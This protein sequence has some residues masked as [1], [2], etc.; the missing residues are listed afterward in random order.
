MIAQSNINI[1]AVRRNARMKRKTACQSAP[2]ERSVYA[3]VPAGIDFPSGAQ[4]DKWAACLQK[5]CLHTALKEE[6]RN[7][8]FMNIH[9]KAWQKAIGDSYRPTIVSLK[10]AGIIRVLE[11]HSTG[12]EGRPAF[13]KS[14]R[15]EAPY[16]NRTIEMRR[17][18]TKPA[19]KRASVVYEV[20]E[21]NLKPA[22]MHYRKC[23]ER[24]TVKLDEARVDPVL[25]DFWSQWA[26][27]RF[28]TG[29]EFA[30]RCNYGRYHSLVTQLPRPS[31]RH[32]TTTQGEPV[33]I[34]DVSACQPV[35]LP[36]VFAQHQ[37]N[38]RAAAR[39][40]GSNGM[41]LSYDARFDRN[42]A[43]VDVQRWLE[44]AESRELYSFLR[45]EI[46]RDPALAIGTATRGDGISFPIDHRR[47]SEAAFKQSCLIP[48][49]DEIPNMLASPIFRI[50]EGEFPTIASFLMEIK[51]QG[52]AR[53]AQLLQRAESTLMI[54]RLGEQ[55]KL[56]FPDEPVQPIHDALLVREGFAR[57]AISLIKEQFASVGLY[58]QVKH[59][60]LA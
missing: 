7:G 12:W 15:L 9:H 39:I 31:R 60:V 3:A 40:S 1:A 50:I 30:R 4:G 56:R 42:S 34:V 6:Y 8:D 41:L 23:F 37:A 13:T 44:M 19:Q 46:E 22:G 11:K 25:S 51:Q 16:R 58:P 48:L 36:L 27:S 21:A 35:L 18:S 24:F 5:L 53:V 55:L 33:A 52:H 43:A 32:L 10:E 59:E 17:I 28:A 26:I 49:F 2:V 38:G 29:R 20:D 57:E 14:Y 47:Q 45:R 54:D